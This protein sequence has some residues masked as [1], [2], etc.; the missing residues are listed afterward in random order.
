MKSKKYV[1]KKQMDDT[2][3]KDKM[4]DKKDDMRMMRKAK[5]DRMKKRG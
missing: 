4:D 5:M 1:T 3:R 2:M